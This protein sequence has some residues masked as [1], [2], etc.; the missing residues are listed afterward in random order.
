MILRDVHLLALATW[1]FFG[2]IAGCARIT[3]PNSSEITRI[4]YDFETSS[5]G[6]IGDFAD[7]PDQPDAET[8]YNFQFSHSS[9]PHPLNQSDGA[10]MQSGVNRSDDLFMFIKKKVNGLAPRKSYR[11][12]I[13]VEFAS[14]AA[15]GMVGVGGAP[16]ESVFIKAGASANEPGKILS[17]TD[18][19]FRMNL[20]KGNQSQ[21][22]A[23]MKLIGHFA[24]GTDLNS[25][26][27]KVLKTATPIVVQS[28]SQGEIWIV[29]GTDSGFEGLTR[30]YYNEIRVSIL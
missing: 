28:N 11:V 25:Y 26:T 2:L 6:W 3:D 13:E 22:G 9:L 19:W 5:Q 30:I 18:Q 23:D 16:G 15:N 27:L 17:S 24:N 21:E 14:N 7:Y 4:D 29:I 8:F 20:D 1:L 10:L 12:D